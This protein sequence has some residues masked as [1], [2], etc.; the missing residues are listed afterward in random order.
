[1]KYICLLLITLSVAYCTNAHSAVIESTLG[2]LTYHLTNSDVGKKYSNKISSNGQLIYTGL[3]G[4]GLV[5]DHST[6]NVFI[7]QNSIAENIYGITYSYTWNLG[8]LNYGPIVGFYQQ[9]DDKFDDRG[10]K[11]FSIGYGIVPIIGGYVG[12]KLLTLEDKY[13]KLNTVI[14]PVLINETISLGIEF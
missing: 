10:I 1:M 12:L 2:G 7:G 11:P 14:T 3:L 4:I 8:I 13:I 5:N 6:Y 9:N